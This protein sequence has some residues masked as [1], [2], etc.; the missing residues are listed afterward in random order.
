MTPW[1]PLAL[2]P[3]ALV[4]LSPAADAQ[5]IKSDSARLVVMQ[6]NRPIGTEDFALRTAGPAGSQEVSFVATT[7]GDSESLRVVVTVRARRLTIRVASASGEAAREY[8]AG[9]RTL[10]V[11]ERVMSLFALVARLQTGPV[12][13]Y[14]PPPG[15]RRSATLTD[16]G[17]DR[18]PGMA[19]PL[20]HLVL[21]SGEDVVDIWLDAE[22]RLIRVA[23]PSRD[24]SAERVI[25]P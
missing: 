8:P 19:D 20:H 13:V 4:G 21:R 14:G 25:Q 1:L 24:L 23:I 6:G 11:D 3:V 17:S 7:N 22:G 2:V 5:T 9:P 15:G 16:A 12:T 18:L 10:V